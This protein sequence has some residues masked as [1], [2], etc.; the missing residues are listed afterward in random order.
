MSNGGL[1]KKPMRISIFLILILCFSPHSFSQ[2]IFM[3][4]DGKH[5]TLEMFREIAPGDP[6]YPEMETRYARKPFAVT[7]EL[8]RLGQVYL[9]NQGRGGAPQ[10]VYLA[11]TGHQG[12]F[13]MRGFALKRADGNIVSMPETDY[14]DLHRNTLKEKVNQSGGYTLCHELGH[15]ILGRLSGTYESNASSVHYFS[16][17]TEYTTA[18]NEGWGEHF[19]NTALLMETDTA[20]RN[21]V[22]ASYLSLYMKVKHY[23]QGYERDYG[24]PFRM[25]IYRASSLL[26]YTNLEDYKRNQYAE[27][28]LAKYY[29][30]TVT[31][32][33]PYTAIQYRNTAVSYDPDRLRTPVQAASTEGVVAD[34]LYALVKEASETPSSDTALLHLYSLTREEAA[35]LGPVMNAYL[36]IFHVMAKYVRM[37]DRSTAPVVAFI[38]GYCTEFPDEKN[39]VL[40]IWEEAS[41][42]PFTPWLPKEEWIE[43]SGARHSPY[44]IIQFGVT[45]PEYTFNL[46][47][48]DPG[49]LATLKGDSYKLHR[50]PVSQ[51]DGG[52]QLDLSIPKIIAK[53][54]GHVALIALFWFIAALVIDMVICVQLKLTFG[55]KRLLVQT[56][57]FL[58]LFTA[59]LASIV[60]TSV[61]VI[62]F[63]A[64][65]LVI[66][67][68]KFFINRKDRSRRV[69]SLTSFSLLALFFAYSLI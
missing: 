26:W 5:D 15:T 10:P 3:V 47:T 30:A 62:W 32:S 41:G 35:T 22:K 67:M 34:F 61:P 7:A 58:L 45:I 50:L 16:I 18:F 36:K 44:A 46:H 8:F 53:S 1:K 42:H 59:A 56:G 65:V 6:G 27:Q 55:W 24:W 64:L 39:S 9:Q 40:R 19:E 38:K 51:P 48:A 2:I 49:D 17:V 28:H 29:P 33:D 14:I 20:V 54:V 57:M 13:P 60:L 37:D 12:G 63:A 21:A 68:I 43:V 25:D 66:L 52:Q 23:R 69:Y 4:P 31:S 11:L